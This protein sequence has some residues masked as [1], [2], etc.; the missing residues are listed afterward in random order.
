MNSLIEHGPVY[1][2]KEIS[3]LGFSANPGSAISYEKQVETGRLPEAAARSIEEY[4][5]RG[6]GMQDIT[7]TDDGCIDGRCAGRVSFP[8]GLG[9]FIRKRPIEDPSEHLRA[10]VA[11]GGYITSLAML[12]GHG[13]AS[14]SMPTD[15]TSVMK[16]LAEKGLFCGGHNGEHGHGDVSDCGANDKFSQIIEN[17]LYFQDVISS[18]TAALLEIAGIQPDQ[19]ISD[20]V[21]SNWVKAVNSGYGKDSS[22]ADRFKLIEDNLQEIQQA[23]T[24]KDKPLAVTK[25]LKGD[26]KEAFIIIN[27]LEGKTF[28]QPALMKHLS[29]THPDVEAQAFVVDVQRIVTLAQAQAEGDERAFNEALHAGIAFQLATAATLTD[30]SLRTFI[31]K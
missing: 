7:D 9:E 6:E 16:S 26:H 12:A 1:E 15:L 13:E 24:P 25:D 23:A 2:I 22:G 10:K 17:G 4:I 27:Y 3:P 21:F 20:T 31:I 5:Y 19:D 18:K 29:E 11:G 14:E 30:G 28:S 8:N